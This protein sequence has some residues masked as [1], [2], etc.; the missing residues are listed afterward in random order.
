MAQEPIFS[1]PDPKTSNLFARYTQE[2]VPVLPAGYLESFATAA[3][4]RADQANQAN[5][6]ALE[7]EKLAVA[8]A[9]KGAD[10]EL[11][12][13][14]TGVESKKL[15]NERAKIKMKDDIDYK[16]YQL[17]LKTDQMKVFSESLGIA[18][19]NY[20]QLKIQQIDD[21]NKDP[22]D[23]MPKDQKDALIQ[24][25]AAAQ[26]S[27]NAIGSKY[28]QHANNFEVGLDGRPENNGKPSQQTPEVSSRLLPNQPATAPATKPAVPSVSYFG[29]K[30]V[31]A[32]MAPPGTLLT[33]KDTLIA[34]FQYK[35]QQAEKAR[36][37]QEAAAM[38]R[39]QARFKAEG[40]K[41]M[42]RLQEMFDEEMEIEK[43]KG[44]P[45]TASSNTSIFDIPSIDENVGGPR[46][47]LTAYSNT[48][49]MSQPIGT[50]IGVDAEG[51]P[52]YGEEAEGVPSELNGTVLNGKTTGLKN[53]AGQPLQSTILHNKDTGAYTMTYNPDVQSP[54]FI[55]HNRKLEFATW[56]LNSHPEM[57]KNVKTDINDEAAANTLFGHEGNSFQLGTLSKAWKLVKNIEETES[58]GK[59][60]QTADL[61]SELFR[62]EFGAEPNE[63]WATGRSA[64]S[65]GMDIDLSPGGQKTKQIA[66]AQERIAQAV[67]TR[68]KL[69]DDNAEPDDTAS[70]IAKL[71]KQIDVINQQ[72]TASVG[73]PETQKELKARQ[74]GLVKQVQ[75]VSQLG[76]ARK[77]DREQKVQ[78][79]KSHDAAIQSQLDLIKGIEHVRASESAD[80]AARQ[81]AIELAD[82]FP[83]YNLESLNYNQGYASPALRQESSVL[84]KVNQL[85]SK[86]RP[87]I[88]R[89]GQP[90]TTNKRF[91]VREIIN[92]SIKN[93]KPDNLLKYWSKRQ[94][95]DQ[96]KAVKESLDSYKKAFPSIVE[97]HKVA[98]ELKNSPTGVSTLTKMLGEKNNA[99]AVYVSTLKAAYRLFAVGGGNP[100]NYEQELLGDL[101]PDPNQ[102]LSI[103]GRNVR[104]FE[105]LA[106]MSVLVNHQKMVEN[107]LELTPQALEMYNK[108]LGP[109]IG[110]KITK[111]ELENL[112][113]TF[114]NNSNNYD[115]LKKSNASAQNLKDARDLMLNAFDTITNKKPE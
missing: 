73:D 102:I 88:G 39:A 12:F 85:D 52:T 107:G 114:Q 38:Q 61:V 15:D 104:R 21:D 97:L 34:N 29:G 31:D 16:K 89:D 8:S 7:K 42:P 18:R 3:K 11:D 27:V 98:K 108:Q 90:L 69:V 5:Q 17:Q 81:K 10:R 93:G 71:N 113:T 105:N 59:Y 13:A 66:E 22:K 63:F 1:A 112:Y 50:Q 60:D 74:D 47:Q 19:T 25:I 92:L 72:M 2:Q 67:S 48:N 43:K 51:N 53:K 23:R 40:G 57:L 70:K 103:D 35:A 64:L 109:V 95:P 30:P 83:G 96:A 32:A 28:L 49:P 26:A 115:K 44:L 55:A 76:D 86:G 78:L 36:K 99:I 4:L 24:K 68:P 41:W 75:S 84:V 14:K 54:E 94:T 80:T 46:I 91:S 87:V 65:A 56:L 58:T 9:E 6:I 37:G 20:S 62:V 106:L 101:V 45:A 77:N 82:G 100:S 110:R 111:D 33:G 79:A